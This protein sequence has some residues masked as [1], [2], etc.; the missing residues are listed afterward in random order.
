MT[1]SLMLKNAG[2][3]PSLPT[4]RS[5]LDLLKSAQKARP[6]VAPEPPIIMNV[7]QNGSTRMFGR[8]VTAV[9]AA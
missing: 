9:P 5:C 1:G 3:I 2:T 6:N 7:H 4:V 8:S